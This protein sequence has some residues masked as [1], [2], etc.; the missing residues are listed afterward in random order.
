[1]SAPLV[2]HAGFGGASLPFFM[3]HC[4][5]VTLDIDA[6]TTPDIVAD[7]A[8]LP[9][10]GPFDAVFSSHALEHLY[11]HDVKSCLAGFYR[12]LKPGGALTLFVPDLE[13]LTP[14]HEVLYVSPSGPV[15]AHDI[16]YGHSL[17][18][19]SCPYMAHKCGFVQSTLTTALEEA[20]FKD[21][22]VHKL[23]DPYPYNLFGFG[24][25]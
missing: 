19:E 20:G 15:T 7:M 18:L 1:V 16:F 2:L 9:D 13:G 21:V 10:I 22:K 24:R 11:P 3:A 23:N 8:H 25:K 5:E 4:R 12:V 17:Y 14:T 6:S